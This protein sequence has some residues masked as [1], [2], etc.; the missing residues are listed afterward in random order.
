VDTKDDGIGE[1]RTMIWGIRDG[2]ETQEAEW[3]EGPGDRPSRLVMNEM[4]LMRF[5]GDHGNP[6]EKTS[7]KFTR[8]QTEKKRRTER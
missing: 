3:E 5:G 6:G 2:G 7:E 1:N 4:V 8:G